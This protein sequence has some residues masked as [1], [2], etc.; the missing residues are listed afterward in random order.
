M[1]IKKPGFPGLFFGFSFQFTA[2]V[3]SFIIV[4]IAAA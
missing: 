4:T 1:G 2:G 3:M